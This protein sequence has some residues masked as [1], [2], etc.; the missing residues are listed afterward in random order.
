MLRTTNY[1]THV[2]H[3]D[4]LRAQGKLLFFHGIP[5]HK[6][7]MGNEESDIAAKEV[8]GWRRSKRRNGNGENGT[9]VIR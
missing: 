1:E 6:D 2:M 9:L 3:F 4:T 8:T 5:S 7:I